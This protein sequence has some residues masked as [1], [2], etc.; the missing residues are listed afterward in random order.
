[1]TL[2]DIK[3]ARTKIK[4]LPANQPNQGLGFNLAPDG[5]QTHELKARI[6]KI[7][8]MCSAAVSTYASLPN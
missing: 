6:T 3:G 5:Q 4:F 7:K 1:M 8:H 2:H